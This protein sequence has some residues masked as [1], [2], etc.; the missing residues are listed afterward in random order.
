[1][2]GSLDAHM[3]GGSPALPS[4]RDGAVMCGLVQLGMRAMAWVSQLD[5]TRVQ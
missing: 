5:E 2:T 1:M 3:P 4:G